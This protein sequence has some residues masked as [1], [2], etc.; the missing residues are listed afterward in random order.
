MNLGKY[1]YHPGRCTPLSVP[2]Q[3]PVVVSCQCKPFRDYKPLVAGA[4]V[5]THGLN[6]AAPYAVI[7]QLRNPS[8]GAEISARVYGETANTVTIHV[9][10]AQPIVQITIL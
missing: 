6:R 2:G 9:P 5:I 8:T 4:N 1:S 7:V 10:S 3:A